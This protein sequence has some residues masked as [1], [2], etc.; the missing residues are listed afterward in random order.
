[1]Q[2]EC[3]SFWLLVRT[4]SIGLT[5]RALENQKQF[6][7]IERQLD[8]AILSICRIDKTPTGRNIFSDGP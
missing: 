8:Q 4:K 7:Y 2:Y 3:I 5:L 6:E 1:M